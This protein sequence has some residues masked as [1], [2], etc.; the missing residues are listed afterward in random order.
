MPKGGGL[1][2]CLSGVSILTQVGF[3]CASSCCE[4]AAG[5]KVAVDVS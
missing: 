1:P 3:R 4:D 5:F 2:L